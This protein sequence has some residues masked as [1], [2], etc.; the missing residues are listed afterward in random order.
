MT[1]QFS[2]LLAEGMIAIRGLLEGRMCPPD[3]DAARAVADAMHNL[4]P[5]P[6]MLHRA[7]ED[8]LALRREYPQTVPYLRQTFAW[9][10]ERELA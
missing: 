9:L 5:N 6:M 3:P 8:L 1:T 10:D 2:A 7:T 4:Q